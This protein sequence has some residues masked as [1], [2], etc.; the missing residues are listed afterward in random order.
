MVTARRPGPGRGT[1]RGASSAMRR[2]PWRSRALRRPDMPP[3]VSKPDRAGRERRRPTAH[4]VAAGCGSRRGRSGARTRRR[5]G[6]DEEGRRGH[7]GARGSRSGRSGLGDHRGEARRTST[8]PRCARSGR[9]LAPSLATSRLEHGA[10]GAVRHAVPEAVAAGTTAVVG[11]VGALH[12]MASS[13]SAVDRPRTVPRHPTS[14]ARGRKGERSCRT[15]P[16]VVGASPGR[17]GSW[18]RTRM[19][20]HGNAP[21]AKR[22]GAITGEQL[23]RDAGIARTCATSCRAAWPRSV[24]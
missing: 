23:R 18:S 24:L 6:E 22:R 14:S 9:Q 8:D 5:G 10:P 21:N 4:V 15:S 7:R 13:R 19:D 12:G 1:G 17:G 20:R 11:L 16:L 2:W 3:G